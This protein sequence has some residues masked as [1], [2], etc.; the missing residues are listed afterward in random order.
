MRQIARLNLDPASV[1]ILSSLQKDVDGASDPPARASILWKRQRSGKRRAEAFGDVRTKLTRMASGRARCM[2]CEDNLG[3]DI[4]HFHPK[5]AYSRQAFVWNN[6]LVACSHCNSNEKRAEFPLDPSGSA[7]LIDPTADDPVTH[8]VL[9]PETGRL[10][11]VTARG[12][13]TERVFG[14]NRRDELTA[15]R[16]DTWTQLERLVRDVGAGHK[17][18][19]RP[20]VVRLVREAKRLSFQCVVHHFVRDALNLAPAFVSKALAKT[21]VATASE[22]AW[23]R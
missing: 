4:D 17:R 10:E 9:V 21:I 2:Y 13:E 7:L 16:A 12:T 23:A 19:D 3:T 14:L 15:G 20:S 22:W 8:L 11:P 18:G 1:T 6:Y 5:S